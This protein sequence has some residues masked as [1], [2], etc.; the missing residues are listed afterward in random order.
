MKIVK[1]DLQAIAVH[2]K[3]Y[4]MDQL[5]EIAFAG[6]SNVGKSSFI[7]SMINR[8]NLARTSSKPGKTRT[9][10]F[11]IIND[12]FRF[13]DLPGYGYAIASKAEKE[14]W[15]Q[16]IEKYLNTR[17]NL[18]D[19]VLLVD[20]R[21]EPTDLDLM[22]YQW[23]KAFGYTGIVIATKADKISRGKIQKHISV[24]KK[25]LD[26]KDSNLVIPYSAQNKMNKERVWSIFKDIL[27][28]SLDQ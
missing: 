5:P 20:I 11:Y 17:E 25:K 16:I 6:R 8:T 19:V 26:I 28:K 7:N 21:H 24:I 13:V 3:Q 14:K 15:R 12:S 22:M 2:P 27:D 1:S 4:P 10:N 18:K 9:I 23:I